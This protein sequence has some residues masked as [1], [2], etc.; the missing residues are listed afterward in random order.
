MFS[1]PGK[2]AF[3]S[4]SHYNR[5]AK[6]TMGTH[7][8]HEPSG[9]SPGASKPRGSVEPFWR[10]GQEPSRRYVLMTAAYNEETTIEQ[11]IASILSQTLLPSRWIIAS[12]GSFDKTDMIVQSYANKYDFIRFL[13]ITRSPGRSFNSKV[14]AL[15]SA[16]EL[17]NDVPF[18]FIGNLDA[19]VS[20]NSSYFEDLMARFSMNPKLGLAAGF[21][22]EK[23][24]PSYKEIAS[25]RVHSVAH[26]AQ[27]LRR[28][29]YQAIGGYAVLEYGGEDW[30]AET[31]VRMMGWTA[32]AFPD[33]QIFHHRPT[34]E[35]ERLLTYKFRTGRMDYSLG[36]DPLF[37]A[38]KCLGRVLEKPLIIGAL[39]RWAGFIWSWLRGD[40]RPVSD[41]FM[42]F[43]RKGQRE[44]LRLLV[45]GRYVR[46][47]ETGWLLKE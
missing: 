8:L 15:R 16:F 36:S 37:E 7:P 32:E 11:A 41:L 47:K 31:S 2:R 9:G 40:R 12:D 25:N 28:E 35:A 38:V 23:K 22:F 5:S 44:R 27:L 3:G 26:A 18:E 39:A 6:V 24:G 1:D 43:L 20:V 46:V 29:C 17:T 45:P 10:T 21:I 42:A 30:H 19:D 14:L 4:I 13:R 33:L 34:G